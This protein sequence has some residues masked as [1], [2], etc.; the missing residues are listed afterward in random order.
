MSAIDLRFCDKEGRIY[1]QPLYTVEPVGYEHIEN[2][3]IHWFE[4]DTNFLSVNNMYVKTIRLVLPYQRNIKI[5]VQSDS[6]IFR[7]IRYRDIFGGIGYTY[8]TK[9]RGL[10]NYLTKELTDDDVYGIPIGE[11]SKMY[12]QL[13]VPLYVAAYAEEEGSWTTNI[14]IKVC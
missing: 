14:L 12:K 3:Y 2:D 1:E 4:T 11:K 9:I 7:L 10:E 5:S 6:E 13:L 8:N